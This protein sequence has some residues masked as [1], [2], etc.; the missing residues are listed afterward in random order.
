MALAPIVPGKVA[1]RHMLVNIPDLVS[2][3]YTLRPKKGVEFGTSG[4]RGSSLKGTFNEAHILAITQAIVE[5]RAKE[6]ITGPLF[7]GFDT[8][9]LS[10]PAFRTALE[11]L[12]ANGVEAV[13]HEKDEYSP[14]PVISHMILRHNREKNSKLADGIVI[15]PSHNGPEDGGF[16]YNPPHGGPADTK[17]TSKIE[18]RANQLMQDNNK[19]VSRIPYQKARSAATTHEANFVVP[20]VNDLDNVIDMGAIRSAG[21][22]IG[23]DPMGGSGV[24]F[25]EP[26]AERYGLNIEVVNKVVEPDFRFMTVDKDGTIRMDCS[27]EYA[28]AGLTAMKDRF[29]IAAGNDTDFDRHGIVT[30]A[31]LMNPNHYL[32]VSIWYL[33][34]NRPKWANSLKI[35]KTIVSSGIIDKVV[36]G[37]GRK[38]HEVPV[39]FKWFVDGLHEGWLGFGGEESAGASFLRRN[40]EV[41]TTDKDGFAPVLLAAEIL[42]KTGKSPAEIYSGTLVP[43]YGEPFYKRDDDAIKP[44][45]EEK[46]AFLKSFNPDLIT[47]TTV[48]GLPIT[49]KLVKAP[50]NNEPIGGI[51]VVLMDG[52]W[53]AMRPSGTENKIKFY[54]ESFGGE[55]LWQQI[56]AEAPDLIFAKAA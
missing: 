21:I 16:K 38:S 48:A 46:K 1:P 5:Y 19:D 14:T 15:T 31:G 30:P 2:A 40:G 56:N 43:Q 45:T 54:I 6:G 42:A 29:D 7:I 47:A 44:V 13:I 51:K 25:W 35:G 34:Q 49:A 52:S 55:Q 24:N 10:I 23:V 53:F 12:A 41:W 28:L 8:H 36:T 9:A 32:S 3:Y 27:S 26:I 50:G 33:I 17:V 37:L 22:R 20:F 39:G 11:V 18:E 4:H